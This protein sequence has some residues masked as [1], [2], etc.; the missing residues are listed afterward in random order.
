MNLCSEP[1]AI[2]LLLVEMNLC[3]EPSCYLVAFGWDELMSACVDPCF[4][5]SMCY[6]MMSGC[7]FFNLFFSCWYEMKP[8]TTF[9]FSLTFLLKR[10][11]EVMYSKTSFFNMII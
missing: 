2:W 4:W 1:V 9:L 6:E 8:S 11:S 7:F 10:D 5:L 3:S